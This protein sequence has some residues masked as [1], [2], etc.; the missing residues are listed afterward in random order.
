M[1]QRSPDRVVEPANDRD[2]LLL[3]TPE[4]G[5]SYDD[6][7]ERLHKR[8][9]ARCVVTGPSA[10]GALSEAASIRPSRIV[11][12]AFSFGAGAPW[13]AD[14]TGLLRWARARWPGNTFLQSQQVGCREHV[15]GWA[16]QQ[17]QASRDC[18]S[19]GTPSSDTAVLVAG[20]GGAPGA[21][22]EV[23]ALAGLLRE[24]QNCIVE[25]GFAR[26]TRSTV[27]M[28]I[29]RC[30]RLGARRIIVLP[31]T[32]LVGPFYDEVRAQIRSFSEGGLPQSVTIAA[33][34]LTPATAAAVVYRRY[35]DA[36]ARWQSHEDDGSMP[37]RDHRHI[38]TDLDA[39]VDGDVLPPRYRGAR[40]VSAASMRSAPLTL[41]AQGR[42][43]WDRVWKSFCDLALA[44]GP[45]HRGTLLE[46]AS[47][48]E[49][50]ASPSD[51]ASVVAEI[52]RGL[53]LI[54]RLPVVTD[55]APGWVGL[56]CGDE[57]MAV[58]LL[59][60]IVVENICVR[61]EGTTLFLPA[62]PAYRI[63]KEIKNVI[64]AVAKTHHY[65]AEHRGSR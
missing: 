55:A 3:V 61:R 65:W 39:Y 25:V 21:K 38:P 36:V 17:I 48:E 20:E 13:P 19:D 42:V 9:S 33:P 22:A 44:G 64:T 50:L 52:A 54:T 62:G 2:V 16:S 37:S 29:D 4:I 5:T 47:R 46:P 32:L 53:S 56:V 12:V 60:A 40:P 14:L 59:R 27:A 63:D 34:L 35:T 31:L 11:A 8:A 7:V 45:P 18:S 58:W 28:G 41:D 23:F 30:H 43:A 6:V 57:E 26:D 15:V 51:Y 10:R 1:V 24:H 49:A